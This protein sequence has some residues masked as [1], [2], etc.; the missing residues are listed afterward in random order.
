MAEVRWENRR[1]LFFATMTHH[2]RDHIIQFLLPSFKIRGRMERNRRD[3]RHLRNLAADQ[4][5]YR[6]RCQ[7]ELAV[8][9][10][11]APRRP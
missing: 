6:G 3:E 4:S 10:K 2:I 1:R 11:V 9:K 8:R 5:G 7:P